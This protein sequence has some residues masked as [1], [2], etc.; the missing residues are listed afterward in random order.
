MW[1]RLAMRLRARGQAAPLSFA[2][3]P[4]RPPHLIGLRSAQG[5][6]AR[7]IGDRTAAIGGAATVRLEP[8][9]DRLGV[10]TN[11]V[12]SID[13]ELQK[14]QQPVEPLA[15]LQRV[16]ASVER[17][18]DRPRDLLERGPVSYTHLR[19]HATDYHM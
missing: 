16:A 12:V 14:Q 19:A 3:R 5:G 13:V 6:R 11:V 7:R 18:A 1:E 17:S 8:R 9:A 4:S 2:A 10:S 15:V